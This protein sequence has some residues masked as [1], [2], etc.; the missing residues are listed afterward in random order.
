V[1]WDREGTPSYDAER[2]EAIVRRE[3]P[4]CLLVNSPHN[5]SGLRLEEGMDRVLDAAREVGA[6]CIGDEHY[7]FLSRDDGPLGATTYQPDGRTFVTGSF[8]KC[9]GCPGLRIGWCVGDREVLARM[10]SEKNYTT[11]TV[12]PVTEW[13]AA[14]VLR[15]LAAPGMQAAH[16][17]WMANRGVLRR[18]LQSSEHVLGREPRGGIV[19]SLAFRGVESE[20]AFEACLRALDQAGVFVLPLR[21][22]ELGT[23]DEH[24]G[25]TA[26]ERGLGVRLG[27]SVEPDVLEE[28]LGTMDG[29]LRAARSR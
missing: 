10:Q 5:P 27:L 18:F 2:W 26:V 6:T 22:M 4:D 15:D 12:N 11:H 1:R 29:A 23:L 28:A 3:R 21:S 14:E 9:L 24:R 25:G 13:I 19:T 16:A 20:E 8:I 17:R 7:R